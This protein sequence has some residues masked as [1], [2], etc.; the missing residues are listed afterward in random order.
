MKKTAVLFL[1]FFSITAC[2]ATLAVE[3]RDYILAHP[4]GW[5]EVSIAD[6]AIPLVPNLDEESKKERGAWVKPERCITRVQL[7]EEDFV[8]DSVYPLGA[9]P[10]FEATSGFRFPAPVGAALLAITYSGC[11]VENEKEKNVQVSAMIGVE[12]NMTLEVHFDG[13]QLAFDAPR[14]NRVVTLEDVYEALTG[15]REVMK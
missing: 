3:R 2:A 15:K 4:H 1:A 8:Y 9:T 13:T 6:K 5:V 10:P 12:E 14:P 7:N 11:R